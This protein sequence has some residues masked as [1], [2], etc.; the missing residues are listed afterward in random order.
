MGLFILEEH[1]PTLTYPYEYTTIGPEG[2][3][4]RIRNGNGCFPLGKSTPKF[5]ERITYERFSVS[6]LSCKLILSSGITS[7]RRILEILS[8]S[9]QASVKLS[10][11]TKS[12]EIIFSHSSLLQ[13]EVT[14]IIFSHLTEEKYKDQAD[15]LLVRIS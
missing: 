12:F 5:T 2:L 3:N 7:G 13:E 14:R 6:K 10:F 11:I 1:R 9:K 8:N 4:C 15:W